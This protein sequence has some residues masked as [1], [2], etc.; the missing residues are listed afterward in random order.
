MTL[1][2][3][4]ILDKDNEDIL[5]N[6]NM[7]DDERAIE[8][9]ENK[10]RRPDYKPYEEQDMDEYGML[11][12]KE[13]LNKYDEEISGKKHEKFQLG[14]GGKYDAQHERRMQEIRASIR[15]QG[16]GCWSLQPRLTVLHLTVFK[17]QAQSRGLFF[18]LHSSFLFTRSKH[19][20]SPRRP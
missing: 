12:P 9:V 16:V 15:Q 13:V 8:N 5:V 17:R 6:V 4:G 20:S 14:A 2:D 11:K 19:W 7:M 18:M 1:Q 3:K 10:K